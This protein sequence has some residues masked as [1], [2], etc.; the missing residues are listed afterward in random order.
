MP[1]FKHCKQNQTSDATLGYK[2][3]FF[4]RVCVC[5]RE[6]EREIERERAVKIDLHLTSFGEASCWIR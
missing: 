4:F 1:I 5:E 6:R 2:M 3:Y